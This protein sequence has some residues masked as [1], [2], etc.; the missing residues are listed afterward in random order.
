ML[1]FISTPRSTLSWLA[2]SI[3]RPQRTYAPIILHE[4]TSN[5]T[6]YAWVWFF[7]RVRR[8]L[9]E[10]DKVQITTISTHVGR[11]IG[12]AYLLYAEYDSRGGEVRIIS[13]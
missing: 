10:E 9:V 3:H 1:I 5:T 12:L 13:I 6:K 8:K 11:I 7:A 4:L 2:D